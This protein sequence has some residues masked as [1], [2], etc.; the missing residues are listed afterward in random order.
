M[1]IFPSSKSGIFL[2]SMLTIIR[3]AEPQ[4]RAKETTVIALF[5]TVLSEIFLLHNPFAI[6]N[7]LYI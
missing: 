1:I 7:S 3:K 6:T 2:N 5:H 4:L